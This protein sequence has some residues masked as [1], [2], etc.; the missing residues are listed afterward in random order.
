ME[1]D[2]HTP[3]NTVRPNSVANAPWVSFCSAYQ[4]R[5]CFPMVECH[6]SCK[7]GRLLRIFFLLGRPRQSPR[8]S[9]CAQEPANDVSVAPSAIAN[10]NSFECRSRGSGGQNASSYSSEVFPRFGVQKM[11]R[12][13]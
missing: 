11:R 13:V 4:G 9:I 2:C 1:V 3:S 6:S 8:V 12:E 10:L 5:D 7:R